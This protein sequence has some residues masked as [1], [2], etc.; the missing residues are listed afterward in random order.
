MRKRCAQALQMLWNDMRLQK[1]NSRSFPFRLIQNRKW[2]F[3]LRRSHEARLT[4]TC[5]ERGPSSRTWVER[6]SRRRT[7]PAGSVPCRLRQARSDIH[8]LTIHT[9][10]QR[11]RCVMR[12]R[13]R[14]TGANRK[15]LLWHSHIQKRRQWCSFPNNCFDDKI[16]IQSERFKWLKK[17]KV[18][19]NLL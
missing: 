1:K 11:H 2:K 15:H 13:L 7:E 12:M 4:L 14:L 16:K 17:M 6:W 10:T 3:D 19:L 18:C 8:I 5:W 9:E